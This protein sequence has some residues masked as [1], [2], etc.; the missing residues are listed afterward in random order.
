MSI[1]K[2]KKI[3]NNINKHL[4]GRLMNFTNYYF[5]ERKKDIE[6][7]E[8]SSSLF[9]N[10]SKKVQNKKNAIF[11]FKMKINEMANRIANIPVSHHL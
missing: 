11:N 1:P 5:T 3:N 8:L 6:A 9:Q 10:I 7:V 4:K 2:L